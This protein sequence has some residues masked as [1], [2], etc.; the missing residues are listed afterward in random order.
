MAARDPVHRL[1]LEPGRRRA[2]ADRRRPG[3]P[4]GSAP[5]ACPAIAV[6]LGGAAW[7]AAGALARKQRPR[8][9]SP[10]S[11]PCRRRP[12]SPGRR[13]SP[14]AGPRSASSS[15]IS[16]SRRSGTRAIAARNFARLARLS[17]RPS[18]TPRLLLWPEARRRPILLLGSSPPRR[19][20]LASLL[21]P[22]DLLLTGGIDH[23]FGD[24]GMRERAPPTACSRSPRTAGSAALRQGASRPLWRISADA[25]APV[26]DRP[27]AARA[28][29]SR[30]PTPGRGR[31]RSTCP[32]SARSASS[33][34][35]RS[36]S[37]ARSSTARDRPDFIFNPSN[38]AWFGAWG[39]PQHLAQ[40][41]LRALEE[42]LPVIRATP[43]GISAVIDADGRLL[44]EPAARHG[45]RDRRPAAAR[46]RRRPCSP[47]SATSCPSPSRCCSSRRRLQCAAKRASGRRT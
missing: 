4:P 33:S 38:D 22:R 29:R 13:R 41:R 47:G 10:P 3:P 28:R 25:A 36:S 32:A 15:P 1:R 26:G 16:A 27:V 8:S 40:A 42:G 34:A 20:R 39:P 5:T 23:A 9:W 2:A 43:T 30:L 19:R 31:A 7:L 44:A 18:P 14:G 6:L 35:T 21:G 45:R 17:G 24:D 12:G 37:P 46:A 11:P